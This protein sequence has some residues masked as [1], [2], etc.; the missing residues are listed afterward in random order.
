[1]TSQNDIPQDVQRIMTTM[2]VNNETIR[3][4][5]EEGDSQ[6]V[7][8]IMALRFLSLGLTTE[9]N[10]LEIIRVRWNAWATEHAGKWREATQEEIDEYMKEDDDEA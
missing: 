5:A 6:S 7:E 1:M 4:L 9:E 2:G 8:L 10:A 3:G